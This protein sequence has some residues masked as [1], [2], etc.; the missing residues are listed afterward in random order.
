MGGGTG[1]GVHQGGVYGPVDAP[2]AYQSPAPMMPEPDF[3]DWLLDRE[4]KELGQ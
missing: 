2:E 3:I 4:P 1:K